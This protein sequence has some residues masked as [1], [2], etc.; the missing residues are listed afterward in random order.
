MWTPT[1]TFLH[2]LVVASQDMARS[3]EGAE[4]C[5]VVVSSVAQSVVSLVSHDVQSAMF[6]K[7]AFAHAATITVFPLRS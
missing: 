3:P 6:S 4:S 5:S 2:V 7:F 1:A